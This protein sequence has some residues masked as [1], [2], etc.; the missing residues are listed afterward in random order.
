MLK[1]HSQSA[2]LNMPRHGV[3]SLIPIRWWIFL[4]LF[5]F[6][7]LAFI[8]Q[9]SLSI[10]ADSILPALSLS[11]LQVGI[12]MWAFTI[13]YA[14][15]QIPGG[16]LGQRMGARAMFVVIG[17]VSLIATLALPL[18]PMLLSGGALFAVLVLSQA[19]LGAAQAPEFPTVAGVF[20]A[21]FPA[22]RWAL[23]N[24]LNSSGIN[25]GTALTPPLI[26]ALT[27]AFGWQRAL[28]WIALP[29]VVLTLVWAWYGRN[30]PGE[31][32]AVTARELAELGAL[33]TQPKARLSRA[34]F[35]AL[36]SDRNVLLLAASYLCMNYAFYLLGNWSFRY[37]IEVRHLGALEGGL[38]AMLPPIGA[39]VGAWLG[40]LVSD[41]LALRFGPRWGYR[42]VPLVTLPLVGV[43]LLVAIHAGD[44]YFAVCGL[45]IAFAAVE[46]NEGSY[47]AAT[48]QVARAD[49]MAASGVLNTGGN[50]GGVVNIPIVTWLWDRGDLDAAFATGS[51]FALVAAALWLWIDCGRQLGRGCSPVFESIPIAR[52]H[53]LG[54][55]EL[56]V[57]PPHPLGPQDAT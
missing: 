8:Q 43:L 7:M 1:A 40:G 53:G 31:H 20:E 11:K 41:R 55:D 28:L 19:L 16:V 52:H 10:A 34:R 13:T 26:V 36:L 46:F 38:L 17:F 39:A 12:M 32:K 49:T 22:D 54:L 14:G 23:V 21:W 9:K 25:L 44:A 4:L 5:L 50:L 27:L 3:R 24:G 30:T 51:L 15:F 35:V 56:L 42:I 2:K 45:T 29:T 18:A 48:M 33:A 6:A 37:L 47:W 57:Q